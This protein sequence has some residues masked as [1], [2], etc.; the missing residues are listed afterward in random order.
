MQYGKGLL[1]SADDK[2]VRTP[3]PRHAPLDRPANASVAIVLCALTT[4]PKLIQKYPNFYP[5][6]VHKS[7]YKVAPVTC[8]SEVNVCGLSRTSST[9][10]ANRFSIDQ[11]SIDMLPDEALLEI[12]SFWLVEEY[13]NIN[14]WIPLVHVCRRWRS[15][16]F[17]SPRRLDVRVRYAPKRPVKAMLD[18]WPNLPI[19]ISTYA[20]E[21]SLCGCESN[22]IAALEHTDRICQIRLD[23]PFSQLEQILPAM[24]KQFPALTSL[25]IGCSDYGS[26][27]GYQQAMPVIPEAFLGGSVQDLQSCDL[28]AVEFPGIWKLLLTANHLVTLGLRNIPDSM[29]TSPEEMATCLSTM[30]H[31]ESLFIAFQPSQSLHNWSGQ[32]NR[33]L[34]PTHISLPSLT[35]FRFQAMGEYIEDFVSRIDAPSLHMVDITF[36]YQPVFNTP[37]LHDFLARIE[38]FKVASRGNVA[39]QGSS[40][41]FA[42]E[43]E[44]FSFELA[45]LCRGIGRQVSSMAQL[46]SSSLHLPSALKRLDI[47]GS[48]LV[49]LWY[50]QDGVEDLDPQWLDLFRPFTGLKDLRLGGRIMPYYA[51]A[52]RDLAGERL[53]KVLPELQ[54]LFIEGLG[55]FGPTGIQEAFEQFVA[56]RQLSG[57]PVVLH[58][59][60]GLS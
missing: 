45:I 32:P 12:F 17:A 8:Y 58:S 37:R 41:N 33:H 38:R 47:R 44:S 25:A 20:Y 30:S 5:Q 27:Y 11:M 49:P 31:L 52:L 55:S 2:H 51:L 24:Q 34:S 18:T 10:T 26:D 50:Q 4:T 6:T 36:F 7:P 9:T 14:P 19:Q 57:S 1:Y 21:V 54:N 42:L 48:L 59:W 46:C 60:G 43:L 56:T 16:A 15:I 53:T 22:L 28:L 39:F 23:R 35:K 13:K 3:K 40:I 29:H